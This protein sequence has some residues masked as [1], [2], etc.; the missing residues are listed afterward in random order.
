METFSQRLSYVIDLIKVR[1]RKTKQQIAEEINISPA[2][3]TQ[4]TKGK[5][6]QASE[7]TLN[8]LKQKYSLNPQWLTDGIGDIF[9]AIDGF[10]SIRPEIVAGTDGY[11]CRYIVATILGWGKILNYY[12]EYSSAKNLTIELA[13]KINAW[14]GIANYVRPLYGNPV[15][16]R[17]YSSAKDEND[18]SGIYKTIIFHLEGTPP[19]GYIIAEWRNPSFPYDPH[20]ERILNSKDRIFLVCIHLFNG[21][22]EKIEFAVDE[23]EYEYRIDLSH[24]EYLDILNVK[25]PQDILKISK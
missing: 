24:K 4:L 17:N 16:F 18:Y 2:A 23:Y 11:G 12:T 6:K 8:S 19:K 9:I 21:N 25:P 1:T 7:S 22:W 10:E 14:P 13:K 20:D 15:F 3:L 5:S